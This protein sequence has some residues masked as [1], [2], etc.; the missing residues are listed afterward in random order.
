MIPL[1]LPE[2]KKFLKEQ[3][4]DPK[5]QPETQQLLI[6]LRLADQMAPLFVRIL[7]QSVLQ[8]VIYL[9]FQFETKKLPDVARFLHILNKDL[10]LPGFGLDEGQRVV[11]FRVVIPLLKPELDEGLLLSYL[12][13]SHLV[14][15]SFV[16]A[17]AAVASG[18]A[19]PE[20]ALEKMKQ[21]SGGPLSGLKDAPPLSTNRVRKVYP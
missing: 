15:T 17:I 16:Y 2:I 19:S 8:M 18:Q 4:H 10:D 9:P 1:E 5:D 6:E 21:R 12:T 11:F 7:H 20:D 13:S 14:C 3:G